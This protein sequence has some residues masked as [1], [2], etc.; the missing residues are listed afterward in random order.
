MAAK[1]ANANDHE[2]W[3]IYPDHIYVVGPSIVVLFAVWYIKTYVDRST[4][5]RRYPT[6]HAGSQNLGDLEE[7]PSICSS[8]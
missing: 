2:L 4:T 1:T 7:R 8:R 3:S 5:N 6:M